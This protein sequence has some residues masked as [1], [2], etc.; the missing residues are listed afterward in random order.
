MDP[1]SATVGDYNS[2]MGNTGGDNRAEFD[3]R[4]SHAMWYESSKMGAFSFSALFSPGQNRSSDNSIKASGEPV[5]TGG[6]DPVCNDGSFDNAFSAAGVY[7]AGPLYGIVA[8]ELHKNVNRT[9]DEIPS[10]GQFAPAGAIGIA[11]EQAVKVGVQ[12]LVSPNTTVNAILERMTRKAPNPNFN[13]R[14]RT[15]SWLVRWIMPPTCIRWDTSIRTTSKPRG[16][17]FMP[18]R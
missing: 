16:M 4:I 1:F 13:E 18:A 2:I 11:D 17:P 3:T 6:N 15:G 5:C 7:E 8:Y 10:A 12:Y 9:T 14:Q